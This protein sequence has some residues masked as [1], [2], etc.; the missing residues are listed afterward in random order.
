MIGQNYNKWRDSINYLGV[1][2]LSGKHVST[3][4]NVLKRKFSAGC[5]CTF[6]ECYNVS[7]VAQLRLQETYCLPILTYSGSL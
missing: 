3:D 2:F 6:C 7:E 4:C 1:T 5:N